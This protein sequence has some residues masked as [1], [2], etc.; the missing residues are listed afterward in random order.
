M[1]KFNH[2]SILIILHIFGKLNG[3]N[4]GNDPP[5]DASKTDFPLV[6]KKTDLKLDKAAV[7][8]DP[9]YNDT[10]HESTIIEN[11]KSLLSNDAGDEVSPTITTKTSHGNFLRRIITKNA[12]VRIL[13]SQNV[14]ISDADSKEIT[15]YH[16]SNRKKIHEKLKT[17]YRK[18]F[19]QQANPLSQYYK[20]PSYRMYNKT[21]PKILKV[22]YLQS[23]IL[24]GDQ[25][26][27]STTPEP[28]TEKTYWNDAGLMDYKDEY[29]KW[30]RDQM[31]KANQDQSSYRDS[32]GMPDDRYGRNMFSNR[33][34]NNNQPSLVHGQSRPML[35]ASG[36]LATNTNGV[37]NR[38]QLIALAES[39]NRIFSVDGSYAY[40]P[41]A[42]DSGSYGS[43][44]AGSRS[45]ESHPQNSAGSY[46]F[47]HQSSAGSYGSH[48]Q[49]SAGSYESHPQSSA[50]SYGSHP[51]SSAG[52]YGSQPQS[53]A[54][55]Y[56]NHQQNSAGLYGSHPQS[57]AGAYG[58]QSQSS[59]GSYRSQPQGSAGT[60]DGSYRSPLDNGGLSGKTHLLNAGSYSGSQMGEIESPGGDYNPQSQ[61]NI[62]SS[63]N[64]NSISQFN[65]TEHYNF[66]KMDR[67]EYLKSKSDFGDIFSIL[68]KSGDNSNSP[69]P[70]DDYSTTPSETGDAYS[71]GWDNPSSR[72]GEQQ[73][74]SPNEAEDYNRPESYTGSLHSDSDAPFES[75]IS[76][77]SGSYIDQTSLHSNK[78]PFGPSDAKTAT[79]SGIHKS[80]TLVPSDRKYENPQSSNGFYE[81]GPPAYGDSFG[82]NP[83]ASDSSYEDTVN[84]ASYDTPPPS[85]SVAENGNP[86]A[87]LVPSA[88]YDGA[89]SSALQKQT[90]S[91]E[92]ITASTGTLE[93]HH[94]TSATSYKNPSE[95]MQSSDIVANDPYN[96]ESNAV[97]QENNG[98]SEESSVNHGPQLDDSKPNQTINGDTLHTF[99]DPFDG[100]SID[101]NDYI[102]SNTDFGDIF[103]ILEHNEHLNVK[104]FE[105]IP[106]NNDGSHFGLDNPVTE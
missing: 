74:I 46:V 77:S 51:Q 104:D 5:T 54:G 37:Y 7:T 24:N 57:S 13:P 88:S 17:L 4:Y 101:A 70:V 72:S 97:Q 31:I 53:S 38:N 94:S 42:S 89:L 67:A 36:N 68:A 33:K 62:P 84:G 76:D 98:G 15:S 87:L 14:E 82:S 28:T 45:Y 56:E 58:S 61:S 25:D 34:Y 26:I 43:Q 29:N 83:T 79:S 75:K 99:K 93:K 10:K 105:N 103:S 9:S 48:P 100:S 41:I 63:N 16:T 21:I 30:Y 71:F 78:H 52:S 44:V 106:F 20:I 18:Y 90:A 27:I 35:D 50:G 69:S 23:A 55:S 2:L 81:D 91:D 47:H 49:S 12:S 86:S 39:H 85:P 22:K 32:L 60:Y 64:Y 19:I 11:D 3:N 40:R 92:P 66:D 59:A 73:N 96:S 102:L 8:G 1:I 6:E 80:N 95:T 65:K